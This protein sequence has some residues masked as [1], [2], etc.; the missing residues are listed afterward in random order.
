MN[1]E[2]GKVAVAKPTN[3]QASAIWKP[4]PAV[5]VLASVMKNGPVAQ[6]PKIIATLNPNRGKFHATATLSSAKQ[7]KKGSRKVSSRPVM[8]EAQSPPNSQ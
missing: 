5:L 3:P 1:V 4:S 6:M 8:S 7:Q 2:I